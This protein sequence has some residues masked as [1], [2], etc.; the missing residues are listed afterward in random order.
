LDSIRNKPVLIYDDKCSSCTIFAK[1]A[2]KY[3]RG[4]LDCIGHYSEDGKKFR[5]LIFPPNFNETEMFWIITS[6]R[7]YGGRSGLLPLLGLII[8]GLVMS[9]VRP[10]L[11]P[12]R[13]FPGYCLYS[14]TCNNKEFK[15]KRIYYLL[16]NGK[17]L[18]V[19][20][21]KSIKG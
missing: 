20:Y 3:S 8:K 18:N 9:F 5:K 2:F 4:Q 19:K 13:I 12:N 16:R 17:K 6:N 14:A 15:I 11:A 7:A 21:V 1:Y 10:E